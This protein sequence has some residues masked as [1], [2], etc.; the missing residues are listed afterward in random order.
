MGSDGSPSPEE[1]KERL[2]RVL[3]EYRLV[4]GEDAARMLRSDLTHVLL[5]APSERASPRGGER[6]AA[7]S[8]PAICEKFPHII[9]ESPEILA[10]FDL[11]L[12]VAATDATVLIQGESGTGKELFARA[13]HDLSRRRSGPFV[14]ENC[15]ALPDTLLESELFGHSKGA[16]TGADRSRKGRFAAADKGTLFLDEVGDM[17][18]SLQKKLLRALQEGEIRPVGGTSSIKVDVRFVSASNK[19]LTR[20]VQ[21]RQFREDLY[22]RL[23]PVRIELPPL[24][25]RKGDVRL[26]LQH[27]SRSIAAELGLPAVP[28]FTAAAMEALESYSWPGNI[29]ELQNE[30]QRCMALTDVHQAVDLS[31]LSAEVRKG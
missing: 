7:R 5:E 12:R 8:R 18:P 21:E 2:A 9:G 24:R 15:A 28:E 22:Y 10:V 14:A 20:L 16:F 31:D 25:K 19:D 27:L 6:S 3:S 13:I 1:L 17:S 26:L 23:T 4:W 11:V 29:R 30:L